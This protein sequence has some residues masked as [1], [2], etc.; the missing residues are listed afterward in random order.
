MKYYSNKFRLLCP[1]TKTNITKT[2]DLS[3]VKQGNILIF[4]FHVKYPGQTFI[5][6]RNR[7][8]VT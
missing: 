3:P 6:S 2:Q 7:F 4:L 1:L 8:S 5:G